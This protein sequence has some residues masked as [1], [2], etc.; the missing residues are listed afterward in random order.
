MAVLDSD[1]PMTTTDLTE[2]GLERRICAA[3]TGLPCEPDTAA[4]TPRVAR[5]KMLTLFLRTRPL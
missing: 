2:R 5:L 4:S 1:H 3:L